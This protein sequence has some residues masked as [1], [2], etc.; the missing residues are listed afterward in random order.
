MP[1]ALIRAFGILKFASAQVNRDLGKID[2]ERASL[3]E[4]ASREVIDGVLGDEFP[5]G[6]GKP[7]REHKPT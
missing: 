6:Y 3:I 4:R 7:A 5:S 2:S 1:L